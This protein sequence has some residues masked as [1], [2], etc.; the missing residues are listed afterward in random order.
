[1]TETTNRIE[2]IRGL[3]VK[4]LRAA[5][6]NARKTFDP[7][8]ISEL[9]ASVKSHG[10]QVPLV[11]RAFD[12][13]F[14]AT[15]GSGQVYYLACKNIVGQENL[16]RTFNA[17]SAEENR[18]AAEA[19]A[20]AENGAGDYEIVA[21]HRRLAAAI[22]GG[23]KSV[24]C[25]VREL[26]D[27]QA[28]EI[29]L[30]D[31]LQ[32]EDVPALEE[33]DA[34]AELRQRL[35]TAAAIAARVG[36]DVSYVA[37]R[38]QLVSLAEMPRKALAERLITPD[39]A[40]L[41]AR[42]GEDEQNENLKWT[43]DKNA[44]AKTALEDVI[45]ERI[46]GR[47][48]RSDWNGYWEPQSVLDL[49]HHIEQHVGRKLSRAPWKLDDAALLQDVPACN[50]CP[51]NT[52]HN[53]TLFGDMNIAAATCENGGCFEA[54]R[55][56]FVELRIDE[57]RHSPHSG[58]KPVLRLS[59]KE[60]STAPRQAKDGTGPSETQTF[61]VGQWIEVTGKVKCEHARLGV[62][63][64]WSDDANR[65]YMGR[66]EK[67]R[68]P[69]QQ[70][71]VCIDPKCKAHKKSYEQGA[72]KG[73][74]YD[75]KAEAEKREKAKQA[76]I[77]D[78][79]L[80]MAV[81]SKAID[82]IKQIPAEALR[83]LLSSAIRFGPAEQAAN[84]LLPGLKKIIETAKIDSAEFAKAVAAIVVSPHAQ[85]G[86]WNLEWTRKQFLDSMKLLGVKDAAKAWE[87]PKTEQP[88]KAAKKAPVKKAAKAAKKKGG[89][90]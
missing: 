29:G 76:A 4:S 23:L 73:D 50:S 62:T 81:A 30:V 5:S 36:K 8:S 39:H 10:I 59:W 61:R 77:A 17:G 37:R 80:R 2:E 38:L 34:Y 26:T 28:R 9:A 83:N 15:H 51:S 12:K 49:K 55:Q 67:L 3:P 53:D 24:P 22:A 58:G 69:G 66:D 43:L 1:M 41:L 71:V 19:A 6:W 54:K 88:A 78:S 87:Q 35:G 79:K 60:T 74:R 20:E 52:K 44:G 40:L 72:A 85:A 56:R 57:A 21:G 32:R 90:K 86:E 82:G 46:K 84:A 70:I 89:R 33:A 48:K 14:Y 13:A 25:I 18:A 63:V 42:L 11:V 64:D 27:D 65:G 68:K 7:A 75:E 16:L 47:D 45:Q 31:N